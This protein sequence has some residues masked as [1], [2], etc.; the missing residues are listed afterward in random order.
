[1]PKS[2]Y[3]W[4]NCDENIQKNMRERIKNSLQILH[5][6]KYEINP[7]NLLLKHQKT[8]EYIK[9]EIL[10]NAGNAGAWERVV[11]PFVANL[12]KIGVDA[13]LKIVETN[14]FKARLDNYDY[15]MIVGV[16]P[17]SISPGNEQEYYFGS[18]Y[19]DIKGGYNYARVRDDV[20]D[21]LIAGIVAAK[22]L[23]DLKS[24][25]R[26][27]D[28]VLLWNY[29]VIPNWFIPY[30]RVAYHDKFDFISPEKSGVLRGQDFMTWWIK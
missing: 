19:A 3:D 30:N 13:S 8:G 2:F 26:A 7:E 24:W 20:I 17:M 6:E 23:E 28:R 29:F 11:L 4:D 1:L 21:G 12:R 22:N 10:I 27:Y 15:D 25:V 16:F 9:F 5:E 14:M 18:K